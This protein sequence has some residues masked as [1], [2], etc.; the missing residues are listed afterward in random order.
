MSHHFV[1]QLIYVMWA[2]KNQQY[3]I[4]SL[5]RNQLYHY[6]S[7]IIKSN[8]GKLYLAGGSHDHIHCLISMAPTISVSSMMRMIK[9][10]TSKWIKYQTSVDP[11]FTWEDGYTAISVQNDRVDAVC[12][13]ILDDEKRH[14]K[15]S[16]KEELINLLKHQNIQFHEKYYMTNTHTKLLLHIVWSTKNRKA[17]LAKSICAS[18]YAEISKTVVKTGGIIHAI[19]GIEDH[20]HLLIETNRNIA[21]SDVIK[22]IKVTAT[23]W[24]ASKDSIFS[25]F[26]WQQGYG[27]FSI[28]F[29]TLEAVNQY[30][31]QQEMHHKK[32]TSADEWNTF[33]MNKGLLVY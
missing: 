10:H 5:V 25:D 4:P 27:A 7:T 23:H 15:L 28:S 2:T 20:I 26:E 30:I 6:L 12:K 3:K 11:K 19:G 32:S 18:L 8:E 33:I 16:Y 9:S 24:L 13:Y 21:L 31:R 14:E 1:V 22:E 29:L 17:C